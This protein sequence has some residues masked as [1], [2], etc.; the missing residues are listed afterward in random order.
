MK[1]NI[2]TFHRAYNYGAVLQTYALQEFLSE[3]DDSVGVYDYLAPSENKY[4]GIKGGI[5]KL[6]FGFSRKK[7]AEREAKFRDFVE[8]MLNLNLEN[9]SDIYVSGSDQVW[10]PCGEMDPTYFLRFVDKHSIKASYAASM[11]DTIV[12]KERERQFKKYIKDFDYI[13]VREER[14][15]DYLIK[16]SEKEIF[17]N[18][19]PTLLHTS[20]FWL[21]I[22]KEIKGLPKNYILVYLMHK[23]KNINE[24]LNWLKKETGFNIVI[25]DGQG[26][27]Q[28]VLTN[29]VK[30]DIALHN[31]GPR[32]FLWLMANAKCVV[33]S[34]FH[35]TVFSLIFKK[36]LYSI[37]NSATSRIANVLEI[38]DVRRMTETMYNFKRND[39]INWNYVEN[40]LFQEREKSRKYF[41]DILNDIKNRRK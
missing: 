10:N 29:L 32:E 15:K 40:V 3:I 12:P 14:T 26:A 11:G 34:S 21:K 7:I 37:N 39:K 5:L 9:N 28:G 27:V 36:E 16:I 30:H 25:V 33:T 17:V 6:I 20:E 24:I 35:G 1:F 23:P 4:K 19:D 22:A 2:V 38:C 18:V 41:V 13:S 31:V 8:E